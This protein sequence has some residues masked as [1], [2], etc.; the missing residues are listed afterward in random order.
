MTANHVIRSVIENAL[1]W[2]LADEDSGRR[3]SAAWRL[4]YV[5][6]SRRNRA[7]GLAFLAFPVLLRS[8]SPPPTLGILLTTEI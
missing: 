8:C 4:F 6:M 7:R 5:A 2:P 1:T 3:E